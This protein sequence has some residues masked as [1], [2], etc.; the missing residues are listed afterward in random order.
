MRWLFTHPT[1]VYYTFY[2]ER[3]D[4]DSELKKFRI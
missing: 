1:N 4:M 3:Q 2:R